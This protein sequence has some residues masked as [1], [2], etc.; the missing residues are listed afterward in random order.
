MPARRNVVRGAR[1]AL[2]LLL[3]VCLALAAHAAD[4]VDVVID[5]V[6]GPLA[7]NIRAFLVLGDDNGV[8]LG[9]G[10]VR[11]A[12]TAG[13]DKIAAALQPF[14]YYQPETKVDV[15]CT[16]G[17]CRVHYL[18]NSG[19]PTIIDKLVLKATGEGRDQPEI[20]A[21]IA[22]SRLKTGQRLRHSRY[23][24]TKATLI[25]A[26][27]DAGYLD[28]SYAKSLLRIRPEAASAQV[29]LVL[30]TGPRYYFGKV[31]IKQ[32]ILDPEFLRQY[33]DIERGD[34]FNADRLSDLQLRLASTDYFSQIEI[35]ADRDHVLT[36]GVVGDQALPQLPIT[37]RTKPRD[38]RKYTISAGYGTDTGPRVGAGV[39]FRRL[40]RQGHKFRAD[41]RISAIERGLN[42][43]YIIPVDDVATDKL[44]ISGILKE[45]EFGDANSFI[46]QAGIARHD[47]WSWGNGSIYLRAQRE[48]FGFGESRRTSRLLYYGVS[49][50]YQQ[51]D[52]RLRV[53][54]GFSIQAD[55]HGGVDGVFA[56]VGFVKGTLE[57]NV[58]YSPIHDLRLLARAKVGAIQTSDFASLPP[59]QRFFT[60]GSR[61]VR[62][63]AYDEISPENA[64][65]DDIG[66]Q[67]LGQASVELEYL[68]Y[69]N[70][71][72]ALFFDAGDAPADIADFDPQRAVGIGFRWLSPVGT[73][74]LDFAHPLD[75][76]APD[77]RFHFSLGPDL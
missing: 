35:E 72:A 37:I 66:G 74:R 71:G 38:S 50:G 36:E 34:V 20:Q 8:R 44:V 52:N 62:G 42:A 24:S 12:A 19:R 4:N 23:K 15:S 60:G 9:E 6:E 43:R 45:E 7:A 3:A 56:T 70:F 46:T 65:G 16:E 40:N 69:G 51:A 31:T 27:Y 11:R 57:G 17:A 22:S 47:V 30:N 77:V 55:L 68:F 32:D 10:E 39:V 33:L 14:G 21:A 53:R 25:R 18:V 48:R 41:A 5:G 64:D 2:G 63:Y 49:L 58:V 61:S 75:A 54:D 76:D 13:L 28:A 26:A 73:L 67:Y 29:Y 1:A 59:S